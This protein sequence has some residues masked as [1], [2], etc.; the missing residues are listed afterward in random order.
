MFTE[1][2]FEGTL[3]PDNQD[4][5]APAWFC[6]TCTACRGCSTC[7]GCDGTKKITQL[8]FSFTLCQA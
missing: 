4:Q 2:F 3:V 6:I 7:T 8:Y 1:D 5:V